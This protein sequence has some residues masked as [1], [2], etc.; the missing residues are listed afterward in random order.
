M[1]L[2][3]PAFRAYRLRPSLAAAPGL[4][5]NGTSYMERQASAAAAGH[6]GR[7]GSPIPFLSLSLAK[8]ISRLHPAF[9]R[10]LSSGSASAQQPS[11]DTQPV[12]LV[13]QPGWRIT[14]FFPCVLEDPFAEEIKIHALEE[15]LGDGGSG[16]GGGVGGGAPRRQQQQQQ[17]ARHRKESLRRL[18][19]FTWAELA[20]QSMGAAFSVLVQ[21]EVSRHALVR[22]ADAHGA[23]IGQGVLCL[24]HAF[25]PPAQAAAVESTPSPARQ[26][27]KG[28]EEE[29]EEEEDDDDRRRSLR[30]TAA[31]WVNRVRQG[32]QEQRQQQQQQQ[33]SPDGLAVVLSNGGQAVGVLRLRLKIRRHA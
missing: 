3:Q 8:S 20:S 12:P 29:E 30:E 13:P 23:E 5:A 28:E 31:A 17:A 11:Q 27:E 24:R 6:G 15:A 16:G 18:R 21:P 19:E 7:R 14:V 32:Q 2:S 1:Q 10:V 33:P 25:P 26:G 22:L 9:S 4:D